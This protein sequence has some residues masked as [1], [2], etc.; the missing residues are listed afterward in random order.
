MC[1][2][3]I[4]FLLI[5]LSFQNLKSQQFWSKTYST[6]SSCTISNDNTYYIVGD[7]GF[8]IRSV[9]YGTNWNLLNSSTSL[10]LNSIISFSNNSL[11]VVGDLGII[12][13]SIDKGNSWKNIPI[14]YKNN[15]TSVC[16]FDSLNI[17]I[18]GDSGLILKSI[19]GGIHF[20]K[21]NSNSNSK[22][23]KIVK[24]SNHSATIIGDSGTILYTS[25]KGISWESKFNYL[26]EY[27][28]DIDF[29]NEQI[30]SISSYRG[31]LRTNDSG[32]S[33]YNLT[34]SNSSFYTIRHITSDSLIKFDNFLKISNDSGK[35]WKKTNDVVNLDQSIYITS[36]SIN[37]NNCLMVG[38]LILVSYDKFKS[39]IAISKLQGNGINDLIAFDDTSL[40]IGRDLNSYGDRSFD[41][42]LTWKT[43]NRGFFSVDKFIQISQDSAFAVNYSHGIFK[44]YD[45]RITG[46][47]GNTWVANETNVNLPTNDK[48]SYSTFK[49]LSFVNK[50]SGILAIEIRGDNYGYLLYTR[51]GC[52]NWDTAHVDNNPNRGYWG[53][54]LVNE[55]L[56]FASSLDLIKNIDSSF[57]TTNRI[58]KTIDGGMNWVTTVSYTHLTLPTSDLV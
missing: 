29:F 8:I 54:L 49:N 18:V 31:L 12:L 10:N 52:L 44:P 47:R 7:F 33:W 50:V 20:D 15:L 27:L 22:L 26:S 41:M 5:F 38:A 21:V 57:T 24:S 58:Y 3:Y 48:N 17:L 23:F 32:K 25:N 11:F 9:D 56:G 55:K 34:Q 45:L 39:N 28:F 51:D 2:F 53:L 37:D 30:G 6:Y 1:K 36:T 19:D 14:N 40:F 35:N 13:S 16:S 43:T 42:G 46:D 4:V